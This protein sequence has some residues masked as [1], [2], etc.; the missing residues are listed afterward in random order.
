MGRLFAYARV[1]T[2]DQTT[3]NQLQALKAAGYV[4]EPHR[5]FEEC[6]SG[7]VKA[8]DRPMFRRLVDKLEPGDTLAVLKLDRLGRDA[9]DILETVEHLE[10][11][12]VQVV[13]L[14]HGAGALTSATGRLWLTM[15]AAFAQ[16]ESDRI[17]E[18]TLEGMARSTKKPGRPPAD[19]TAEA[20]RRCRA[21]GFSQ[22]ETRNATG[23]SLSTVKRYWSGADELAGDEQ[24]KACVSTN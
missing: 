19:K 13:L 1:S 20:V 7:R 15:L 5:Y 23:F 22:A 14:D 11:M 10:R 24:E 17:R 9:R 21:R 12:G 4:P 16:F 18:R 8:L 2:A 3:Q 6:I